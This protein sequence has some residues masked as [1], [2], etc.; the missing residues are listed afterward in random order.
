MYQRSSYVYIITLFN[1]HPLKM[2]KIDASPDFSDYYRD[3]DP[4]YFGSSLQ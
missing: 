1:H 2:T 3:A 4:P